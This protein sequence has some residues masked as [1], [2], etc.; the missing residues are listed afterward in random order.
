MNKQESPKQVSIKIN[1]VRYDA[2]DIG[3]LRIIRIN[4][5]FKKSDKKVES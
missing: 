3:L 1:G 2:V 5:V 4:Q